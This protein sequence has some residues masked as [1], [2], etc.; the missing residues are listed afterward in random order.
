MLS[1]WSSAALADGFYSGSPYA[2]AAHKPAVVHKAAPAVTTTTTTTT[3]AVAAEPVVAPPPA[4]KPV[5][6]DDAYRA[7]KAKTAAAPARNGAGPYV[8]LTGM[9][10]W[11]SD[12]GGNFAGVGFSGTE[13]NE[14]KQDRGAAALIGYQFQGGMFVEAEHLMQRFDGDTVSGTFNTATTSSGFS[15]DLN[16][17]LKVRADM[18]NVGYSYPLD[19]HLNAYG[20]A[21]VGNV[22]VKSDSDDDQ[23][24]GGQL[25][26]GL[27]YVWD[28]GIGVRAGYR[29]LDTGKV[30]LASSGVT[31]EDTMHDR[32]AVHSVETG[33]EYHF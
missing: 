8:A 32:V 25:K 15:A 26:A 12:I 27:N 5:T 19:N 14:F 28:N 7:P 20:S 30:T 23:V 24:V 29:F 31:S 2:P 16:D 17:N 4:P 13:N 11:P 10:S 33:L 22:N 9:Y 1:F 18:V 21:G 6:L 3:P